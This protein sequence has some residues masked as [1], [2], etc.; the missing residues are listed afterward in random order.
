[1][2]IKEKLK[3]ALCNNN[4]H[5]LEANKLKY[6]IDERFQDEGNDTLLLYSISDPNSNMYDYLLKREADI[7]LVNDEGENIIHSIVYSGDNKRLEEILRSYHVNINHQSKDGV[8]PLL[9]AIS[10]EKNKIAQTLIFAGADVNIAD[11]EGIAPLHL[12]CQFSDLDMVKLLLENGA[13]LL[14]KTKKGNLP[15]A[16]AA[17]SEQVEIVKLL[18][19]R[20]YP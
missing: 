4:L 10:L 6:S 12:A 14:K 18:F 15:L 19:D 20:M 2:D 8:T 3:D 17:N 5:F 9:L 16:L 13:N 11:S 7:T 1:M